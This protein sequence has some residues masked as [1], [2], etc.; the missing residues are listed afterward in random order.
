MK[1]TKNVSKTARDIIYDIGAVSDNP[2]DN[3]RKIVEKRLEDLGVD[4]T[5]VNLYA[6]RI[7]ELEKSSKSME[8]VD[9]D[10][11]KT[12]L[13]VSSLARRL[14]GIDKLMERVRLIESLK[15]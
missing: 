3:W 9:D 5:K 2:P 12:L 11:R 14:G 1:T 4:V 10:Y 8:P 7:K 13:E 15:V 6:I